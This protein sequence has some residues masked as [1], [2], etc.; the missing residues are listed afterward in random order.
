MTSGSAARINSVDLLLLGSGSKTGE[1][2]TSIFVSS[3]GCCG[4]NVIVV[5]RAS[6]RARLLT[7]QVITP[8]AI[9]Q[10]SASDCTARKLT[11]ESRL[12]M[13]TFV[14]VNGPKFTTLIVHWPSL[15]GG[16]G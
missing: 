7:M 15:F 9:M 4:W 14:A 10:R 5:E 12:L 16:T 2:A 8:G 1:R 11:P 6:P 13:T 3:A